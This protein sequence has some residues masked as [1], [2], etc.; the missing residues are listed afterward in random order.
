MAPRGWSAP[1]GAQMVE[2]AGAGN[3]RWPVGEGGSAGWCR[4]LGE[5]A[6]RNGG[7]QPPGPQ[8][9]GKFHSPPSGN[10]P[11]VPDEVTHRSE[12]SS[13]PMYS[14][15]ILVSILEGS[16]APLM[17]WPEKQ[18]QLGLKQLPEDPRPRAHHP[19]SG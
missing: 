12:A 1:R 11:E 3:G 6:V 4:D 18:G 17:S 13:L 2:P 7:A 14:S 19:S 8:P 15:R 16:R 9:E 10:C 5:A